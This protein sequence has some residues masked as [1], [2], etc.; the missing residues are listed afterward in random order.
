MIVTDVEEYDEKARY[1]TT[2]AKD[3]EVRYIHNEVGYNFRLTNIQAAIG[4]AQL[5]SLP[6][7]LAAKRRNYLRYREEINRIEGLTLAE[8]PPYASN[9]HW[10]Y[11]LQIDRSV[12]GKNREDLMEYLKGHGI[13]TRPVW[14]LNHL[15]VPYREYRSYCIEKAAH[16]LEVTLNIP[17]STNLK[18]SDID[19]V[20]N[21]LRHA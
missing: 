5:E 11:A 8:S 18:E 21:R 20:I 1:L 3:D 6:E 2:Q 13:Q 17:C 9:N 4:V 14:H 10:M 16:M 12:Y 19:I 7:I 15:Q